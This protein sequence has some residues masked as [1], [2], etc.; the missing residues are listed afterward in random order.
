MSDLV[1]VVMATKNSEQFLAEAL[2]SI[3]NQSVGPVRTIVV[4]S[5]SADRTVEIASQFSFITIVPQRTVG[6]HRAWSEGISLAVTPYVCLLDSDDLLT[7]RAIAG[8][9]AVLD[10]MPECDAALGRVEFFGDSGASLSRVRHAL[11][12]GREHPPIPGCFMFRRSVFEE[13]GMFDS[14]FKTFGDMDWLLSARSNGVRVVQHDSIVL[15]KR[16]H[17]RSLGMQ[18]TTSANYSQE[19]L[20]VVRRFHRRR[21][22]PADGAQRV[23]E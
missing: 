20:E 6:Y 7:S 19:M 3:A 8:G 21:I 11:S 18:A 12:S 15:K 5:A 22:T 4:D 17:Q 23:N 9:L 16:V 14:E 1:T 13:F 10:K 2:L